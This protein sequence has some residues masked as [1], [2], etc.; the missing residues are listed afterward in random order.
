MSAFRKILMSAVSTAALAGGMTL[1]AVGV[2]NAATCPS[3]ASPKVGGAVAH[4]TLT[5]TG[6]GVRVAGWLEDTRI[7]GKCAKVRIAANSATRSATA[8]SVGTREQFSFTFP[9]TRNAEVRL[10]VA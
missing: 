6:N 1:G 8:C 2:A 10:A 3:E 5:C 9:G 4:W 7:D